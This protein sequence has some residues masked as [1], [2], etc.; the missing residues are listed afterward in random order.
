MYD[1]SHVLTTSRVIF[2]KPG[3]AVISSVFTW[4]EDRRQGLGRKNL[5][6]LME[7]A[8]E[9]CKVDVFGLFVKGINIVA[10]NMYTS[11][12]FKKVGYSREHQ[13]TVF[14]LE[15]LEGRARYSPDDIMRIVLAGCTTV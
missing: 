1:D 7:L 4:P 2:V 3:L 13:A 14:A 15:T 12:G 8:K 10:V 9:T 6:L 11:F 5:E